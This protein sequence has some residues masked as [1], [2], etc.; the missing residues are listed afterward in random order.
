MFKIK[1]I[2]PGCV[3]GDPGCI[4]VPELGLEKFVNKNILNEYSQ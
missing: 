4:Y 2:Q 3:M 1:K